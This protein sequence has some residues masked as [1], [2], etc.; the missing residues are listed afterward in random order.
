MAAT[1]LN[2]WGSSQPIR[3]NR[4]LCICSRLPSAPSTWSRAATCQKCTAHGNRH[5]C[6]R[7]NHLSQP[8]QEARIH[9]G[10]KVWD[11]ERWARV[12]THVTACC[13]VAHPRG[14]YLLYSEV[15]LCACLV[16]TLTEASCQLLGTLL[17]KAHS[18][19]STT[20]DESLDR[21]AAR[22]RRLTIDKISTCSRCS[23]GAIPVEG[24]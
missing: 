17:F 5:V 4:F 19:A 22:Y 8:W 23:L 3:W 6:A 7:L 18:T 15:C 9:L 10:R 11:R 16:A 20:R 24:T 13:D 1:R 12:S 14:N 2:S 21:I